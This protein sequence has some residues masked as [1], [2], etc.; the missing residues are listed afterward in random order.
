MN[1]YILSDPAILL[2]LAN[3]VRKKRLMINMTRRQLAEKAGLHPNSVANLEN[4]KTVSLQTF[5]QVLRALDELAS[6]DH[7]IPD[8]GISPVALLK[9]KGKEKQR[10]SGKKSP[11]SLNNTL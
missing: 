4:G 3:R 8:P 6:L 11:Q 10:A 5:I 7:F 9:L 2:E 1:W